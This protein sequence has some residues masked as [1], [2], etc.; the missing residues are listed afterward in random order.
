MEYQSVWRALRRGGCG[1][2]N[3]RDKWVFGA[4]AA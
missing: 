4:S 3:S 2:L 1:N